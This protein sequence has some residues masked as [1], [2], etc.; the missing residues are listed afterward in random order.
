[1]TALADLTPSMEQL[2]TLHYRANREADMFARL[3]VATTLVGDTDKAL[4]WA[5]RSQAN[6]ELVDELRQQKRD[7]HRHTRQAPLAAALP[8]AAAE[9]LAAS[10][11]CGGG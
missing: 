2:N 4:A 10:H 7:L 6:Y 11:P 3:C 8:P 1:M 9:G 5:R